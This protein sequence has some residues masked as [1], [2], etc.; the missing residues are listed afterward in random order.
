MNNKTY[1]QMVQYST[2]KRKQNSFSFRFSQSK[3][4]VKGKASHVNIPLLYSRINSS[5]HPSKLFWSP[6][7]YKSLNQS[8]VNCK[9]S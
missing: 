3:R 7:T 9:A 8:I 5:S 2:L 1:R 6:H 4:A